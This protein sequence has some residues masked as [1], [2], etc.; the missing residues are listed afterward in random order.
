MALQSKDATE[1][2]LRQH[3]E[4]LEAQC[5]DLEDSIRNIQPKYQEAL[6][7]RGNFEVKMIKAAQA[8][9]EIQKSHDSRKEE[10]VRLRGQKSTMEAELRTARTALTS[11]TIPQVAELYQSK[12]ELVAAKVENERL[13][14]RI[15]NMNNDLEYMRSN[16][17]NA[18]SA[19]SEAFNELSSLKEENDILKRK[20]SDNAAEIH[21]IQASNETKIYLTRINELDGEKKELERELGKKN[22]ELKTIMNGRRSTRGTS[23]P[24]SPMTN[25]MSPNMRIHRGIGVSSRGNSPGPGES[26]RGI[27]STDGPPQYGTPT[28]AWPNHLT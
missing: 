16:Y 13:Q 18:S 12:E 3:N 4:R 23:V 15:S 27:F 8:Q 1:A 9:K 24:R 6:N 26:V 10:L 25:T 17:Q 7:E 19:A 2:E 14:K 20:A 5:K 11:S 22:E 28:R 21:R